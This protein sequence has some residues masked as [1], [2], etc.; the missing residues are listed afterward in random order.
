MAAL[1][2]A[3]G[4]L[5]VGRGRARSI[6]TKGIDEAP[7]GRVDRGLGISNRIDVA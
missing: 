5:R 2:N 7:I 6:L 1:C 4:P 3:S